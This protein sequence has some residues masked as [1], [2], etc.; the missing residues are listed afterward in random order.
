[1]V[2]HGG[3]LKGIHT[4]RAG[5]GHR[6]DWTLMVVAWNFEALQLSV[7]CSEFL[8]LNILL[9]RTMKRHVSPLTKEKGQCYD[10][11][12]ERISSMLLPARPVM[13]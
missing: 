4:R 6:E 3:L 7:L 11:F 9:H 2:I 8:P 13:P 1:M 10:C 5:D 12:D